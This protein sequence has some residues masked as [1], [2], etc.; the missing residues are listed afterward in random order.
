MEVLSEAVF[1]VGIPLHKPYISLIEATSMLLVKVRTWN[2]SVP[3]NVGVSVSGRSK[4]MQHA[5]VNYPLL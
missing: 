4:W 1:R 2:C 3:G 5:V